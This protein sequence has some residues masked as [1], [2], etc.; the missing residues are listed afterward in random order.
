MSKQHTNI[1]VTPEELV[2]NLVLQLDTGNEYDY[3]NIFEIDKVSGLLHLTESIDCGE[4]IT[5]KPEL[6][7]KLHQ[8]VR[9]KSMYQIELNW[10]ASEIINSL[11]LDYHVSVPKKV[12]ELLFSGELIELPLETLAKL[13]NN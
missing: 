13:C 8:K 3:F 10:K 5:I 4:K 12:K 11:N 6:I 2:N 1:E 9:E 7:K